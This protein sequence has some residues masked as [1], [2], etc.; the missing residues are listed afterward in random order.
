M[1][2]IWMAN[3]RCDGT[4]DKLTECSFPGFGVVSGCSASEDVGVWCFKEDPTNTTYG[5]LRLANPTIANG[6]ISGRLEVNLEGVWGTVCSDYFD[7]LDAQVACRQLGYGTKCK[8]SVSE[9][10]YRMVTEGFLTL[11][12][13]TV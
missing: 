6:T 12:F 4:E 8:Y 13:F 1:G 5:E 9:E 11:Y 7:N 2:P 10:R 3:V